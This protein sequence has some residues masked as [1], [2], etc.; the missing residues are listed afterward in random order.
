MRASRADVGRIC[1]GAA[2]FRTLAAGGSTRGRSPGSRLADQT[3]ARRRRQDLSNPAEIDRERAQLGIAQCSPNP[4]RYEV[5]AHIGLGA[6]AERQVRMV[7]PA[8]QPES[9]ANPPGLRI[10]LQVR[11]DRQ[12]ITKLRRGDLPASEQARDVVV[13]SR[14]SR[15]SN[16]F[17]RSAQPLCARPCATTTG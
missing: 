13:M 16:R 3:S 17:P 11:P 9:I 4:F 15:E 5:V 8:R 2:R 10:P 1:D 6:H 12:E 7:E 14:S